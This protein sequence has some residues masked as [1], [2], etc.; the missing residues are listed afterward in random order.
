[1]APCA[2]PYTI[3]FLD[4][5]GQRNGGNQHHE[6]GQKPSRSVWVA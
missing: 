1:M 4:D 3:L 6:E 2:K 5:I